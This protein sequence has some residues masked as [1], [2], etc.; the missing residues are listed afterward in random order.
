MARSQRCYPLWV[1]GCAL[2][3]L[4]QAVTPWRRLTVVGADTIVEG[5]RR[6]PVAQ[7]TERLPSKQRAV[8][9]NPTW[10]A[11]GHPSILVWCEPHLTDVDL[12]SNRNEMD[13]A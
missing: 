9:S 5:L 7:W 6:V 10:D 12:A 2:V 8:G 11:S 1:K 13:N 4:F 3:P